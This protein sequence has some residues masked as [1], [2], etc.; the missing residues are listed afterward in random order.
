MPGI[1]HLGIWLSILATFLITCSNLGGI[2]HEGE[3]KIT[4]Q[5]RFEDG[6]PAPLTDVELYPED[7]DPVKSMARIPLEKT[8]NLGHFTFSDIPPGRY[9]I[10][11][12]HHKNSLK[13]LISGIEVIQDSTSNLDKHILRKAGSVKVVIPSDIA[14]NSGY[15]YIPGTKFYEHVNIYDSCVIIDSVPAGTIPEIA[16]STQ[17][18][19]TP[20]ILR[21]DIQVSSDSLATVYNPGWKYTRDIVLN[22][23]ASGAAVNGDVLHFPVCIR[24]HAQNFNF[25]DAQPDGSDIRFMKTDNTPLPHE[26]ERWDPVNAH[27]EI[28]VTVD[29]VYG[30]NNEQGFRMYWGNDGADQQSNG[31]SVF[32]TA[33]GYIAVW[34]CNEQFT[35]ASYNKHNSTISSAVDTIGRIGMCKKFNGSDS[36][37]IPGLLGSPTT[38]TLSAWAQLDSTVPGSGSEI[39]TIGDAVLIRMDYE[40]DSIGTIGSIHASDGDYFSNSISNRFYKKSGWHLITFTIDTGDLNRILYIDGD[41]VS[42][43]PKNST[44]IGYQ[45]VGK[46]TIIGKHGNGKTEFGFM[47]RID[48]V[49]V[50]NRPVSAD[51]VKLCYMNQKEIDVLVQSGIR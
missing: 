8:N 2:G 3:A 26:I 29:T 23:T 15:I 5:L 24:L 40:K 17:N 14:V 19:N 27:A 41:V 1:A 39:I 47:G 7:F 10:Y 37:I 25:S 43:P 46:N 30:N 20:Q 6:T 32:D 9:T 49:R 38:L 11:A 31:P 13:T 51:Y 22:T 48:E 4:G 33:N 44:S 34:H 35:D 12:V 16:F 36:V 42:S 28:W 45:K 21:Y 50:Y 18:E